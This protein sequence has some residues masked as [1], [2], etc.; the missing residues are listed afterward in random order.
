MLQKLNLDRNH[1]PCIRNVGNLTCL[2]TLSWR[3]QT[4]VS[5]HVPLEL[6]IY[7]AEEIQTLQLSENKIPSL[8]PRSSFLNLQHLVLASASLLKLSI[9]FG[10]EM[11]NLRKLNLNHN[12]IKD[13]KPLV[14]IKKLSKLYVAGNRITRM[15][16]TSAVL[17]HFKHSLEEFDCR[18]NPLTGGFYAPTTGSVKL[19]KRIVVQQ[20][21]VVQERDSEE[22]DDIDASLHKYYVPD[23]EPED[24]RRYYSRLDD[25]M[26][27]KRKAYELL[28]HAACTRLK[29]LDGLPCGR[30]V[31]D[32]KDHN[33]QRLVELGV[34]KK[35]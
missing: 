10:T 25:E 17:A 35:M 27:L 14:G 9:D 23:Q 24:D 29:R 4:E 22:E 31:V 34:L 19:E 11:P 26:A 7:S 30:K 3:D 28:V 1:I 12:A 6:D 32:E 13:L 8:E 21:Q 18:M 2:S 20:P 33:W 16:R 5:N 15:R